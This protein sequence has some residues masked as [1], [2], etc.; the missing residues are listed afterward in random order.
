MA[1]HPAKR[2]LE[3]TVPPSDRTAVLK[4]LVSITSNQ[5]AAQLEVFVTRLS[6]ALTRLSDQPRRSPDSE[7]GLQALRHLNNNKASFHRMA[8]SC[9]TDLLLQEIG[10]V[11]TQWPSKLEREAIDLSLVTFEAMEH[12]VLIDSLSHALDAANA[13]TLAALNIRIA[14]L[15]RQD[16]IDI[17]RNPFRPEVFLRA[18]ADA[19]GKFDLNTGSQLVVLRQMRPEI[20]LQL[21]PVLHALNEALI[22][23]GILPNLADAYRLK[24]GEGNPHAP[25]GK[26]RRHL[27]LYSRLRRWLSPPADTKS[28]AASGLARHDGAATH[29][30]LLRYLSDLQKQAPQS[31]GDARAPVPLDA[32]VLRQIRDRAPSGTLTQADEN[33]I[34]LLAR[35]FDH[36]F[37]EQ[38]ISRDIKKLL[39]QLQIPLLKAALTDQDFFFREDHPARRLLDTVAKTGVACDP[40]KGRDDPLFKMIEQIVERVQ[41]EYDQQMELFDDAMNDLESFIAQE[42]RTSGDALS[43]AIEEATRQEKIGR[44]KNLAE[45]DVAMRI[46]TGEVAGFVEVFLESQWARILGLAHSVQDTKPE[47][48]SSALKT[49]D[50]LIWSVKPKTSPEE[51]KE[52]VSKLPSMLSMVNAWL[53]VVKWDGPDRVKFFSTLAE[54]HAAIVRTAV[55]LSPRHQ[56][57]ISLNAAQKASERRLDKRAKEQ[58]E[59]AADEF[60]HLVDSLE[61]DAW[62]EFLR[63]DGTRVNFRLAWISLHRSRFVF[64]DRQGRQPFTLTFDELARSFR[65]GHAAIAAADALVDRAFAAA[66]EEIAGEE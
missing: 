65:D 3:K 51:R 46:E 32:S 2:P 49:M 39:G 20:F 38:T 4:T 11:D 1:D 59:P 19:W 60:A 54:R 14:H 57:E 61:P 18:V 30:G 45:N 52:L 42:M 29:P 44:A 48:L 23:H 62:I 10:A 16:D 21:E 31:L 8:S 35:A 50:D 12:K 55:E 26:E 22:A 41:R 7:A 24:K 37:R 13:E 36:L 64:T 40:Q 53:N 27:P 28:G 63:H 33:A 17:A 6:D 15:L 58:T 43:Q 56:L 66:L 25:A 5:V 9:L 34:E 47:V